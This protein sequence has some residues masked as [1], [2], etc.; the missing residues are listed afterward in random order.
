MF[1]S[2]SLHLKFLKGGGG[3]FGGVDKVPCVNVFS[4]QAAI[5]PNQKL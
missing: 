4:L 1:R 5:K 2:H 3:T